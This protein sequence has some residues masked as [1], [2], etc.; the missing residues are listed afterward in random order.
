MR[1]I[2]DGTK[3]NHFQP[4]LRATK[5]QKLFREMFENLIHG[6][7]F[8]RSGEKGVEQLAGM[9]WIYES[10]SQSQIGYLFVAEKHQGSLDKEIEILMTGISETFQKQGYGKHMIETFIQICPAY[11]T[12]FV[13]CFPASETMFQLLLNCGFKT[14]RTKSDGSRELQYH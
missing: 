9:L 11:T 4:F 6:K 10:H 7:V 5:N 8:K 3:N 2:V 12:L 14:I 1:E 13:R